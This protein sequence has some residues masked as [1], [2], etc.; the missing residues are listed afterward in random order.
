MRIPCLSLAAV[1]LACA[2]PA[3]ALPLLSGLLSDRDSVPR[4]GR[5]E[6]SATVGGAYANPD[7]PDQI[8][9]TAEFTAPS[10]RK[11]AIP[12]FH[13]PRGFKVR[14]AADETGRWT[15]SLRAKDASGISSLP[16]TF[17]V[18]ASTRH[19]WI[20][21]AANQRYFRHDDGAPYHG[22]GFGYPWNVKEAVLDSLKA[23]GANTIVYWNSSFDWEGSG[24]GKYLIE[25][26]DSGLGHYDDRKG[27]RVD[28]IMEW[29]EARDMQLIFCIWPHPFLGDEINPGN[30][31]G[32]W[33]AFYGVNPYGSLVKA[34]DFFDD[35]RAWEYQ[36]KLYRYMV[37]RWGYSPALEHWWTV[38]ETPG[39]DAWALR[40]PAVV[41]AWSQ[42]VRDWFKQN[43]PY[44]HPTSGSQQGNED[45]Y[46]ANGYKIFDLSNREIYFNGS[47]HLSVVQE[48]GKLWSQFKKPI[49][50]G[51]IGNY[52]SPKTFHHALW[53]ALASGAASAPYWWNYPD[54]WSPE[55]W[56]YLKA[57]AAFARDIP[58]ASMGAPQRLTPSVPGASAWAMASDIAAFGWILNENGSVAGKSI[59]LQGLSDGAWKLEWDD[60]W[61]GTRVAASDVTVAGG[62]LT[63]QVPAGSAATAGDLAFKLRS[64]NSLS[65]RP[66]TAPAPHLGNMSVTLI[67]PRLLMHPYPA[68]A[69]A[70]RAE[71]YSPEG[72][73]LAGGSSAGGPME[74]VV[75]RL[76][77]GLH[78]LRWVCR[79]KV[80]V[81]PVMP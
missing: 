20:R 36:R 78:F 70:Y 77:P 39:T 54:Q 56:G 44:G 26:A 19:G 10:G 67:G 2:L 32:G 27:A 13:A 75:G 6:L 7:D 49:V 24:G 79:G 37:A 51:E 65:A 35:A 15:Y 47:S 50:I 45:N 80:R 46:W 1:A 30:K 57:Y 81:Q 29:C 62:K 33:E 23:A 60:T 38:V 69:D 21:I 68:S 5:I 16:G 74:L 63:L 59:A 52:K 61:Q 73:R 22:I 48:T 17:T 31:V 64:A 40:G 76:A 42:K 72:R 58:F 66:A 11:W 28:Q 53:S 8:D 3:A 25:S 71:L 34:R 14:F 55:N 4:Y 9:V 12:G 43:D 18:M 41:E